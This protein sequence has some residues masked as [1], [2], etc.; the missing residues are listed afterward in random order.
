VCVCELETAIIM[1]IR[2][3]FGF[4]CHGAGVTISVVQQM[5]LPNSVIRVAEPLYHG[6]CWV[7]QRFS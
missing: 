2:P 3:E 4:F 5:P 6:F 7:I 1:M